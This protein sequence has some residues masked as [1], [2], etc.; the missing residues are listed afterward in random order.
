[1]TKN[2]FGLHT[3]GKKLCSSRSCSKHLQ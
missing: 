3:L 1:M 2:G